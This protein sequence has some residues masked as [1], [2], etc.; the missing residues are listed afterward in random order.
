MVVM[1]LPNNTFIEL[2]TGIRPLLIERK[3]GVADWLDK[4]DWLCQLERTTDIVHKWMSYILSSKVLTKI[5]ILKH[6]V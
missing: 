4:E 3:S 2:K 5:Y 1:K 6:R